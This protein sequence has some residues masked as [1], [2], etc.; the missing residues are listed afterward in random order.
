MVGPPWRPTSW[1]RFLLT[2]VIFMFN[3]TAT[4]EIYTLSLHDALPISMLGMSSSRIAGTSCIWT[5][6]IDLRGWSPP[7]SSRRARRSPCVGAE[8]PAMKHVIT[9]LLVTVPGSLSAQSTASG[10]VSGLRDGPHQVVI[11]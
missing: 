11:N 4:T 2:T 9:M 8:E 5:S 1:G 7:L 3:D 6:R 10:E